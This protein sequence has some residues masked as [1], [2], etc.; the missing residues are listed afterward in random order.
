MALGSWN[1]KIAVNA[2]PE[3]LATAFGELQIVGAEY[4][5]IAYLGSQ[6][7]NGINHAV[8]AEQLLLT[9]KDTKNVVVMIFNEKEDKFTLSNIERVVES[10]SGMGAVT[11]DVKTDIPDDAKAVFDKAFTG[12]VGSK[13]E[14]FAL[15]ATQVVNG[16]DYIFAAEV[17]T[18]TKE[19]V[20]YVSLVTVN[21]VTDEIKFEDLIQGTDIK[22]LNY[23]FTWLK[24]KA[25][26]QGRNVGEWNVNVV[27]D[28]M[29]QKVATA[30]GKLND[31]VGAK[32]TPI[33]YLGEQVV[34]G[35]NHAVLAEQTL[36]LQEPVKNIVIVIFNEAPGAGPDDL[37]VVSIKTLVEGGTGFG[38]T[39]IDVETGDN[40][41]KTAQQL[42]DQRFGG[43]VGSVVTPFAL[44]A[45]QIVR[46]TNFVF[47]CEACPVLSDNDV[48]NKKA[49]LV[50]MNN[51]T[52]DVQFI[53]MLQPEINR[54][55]GAPLGEWP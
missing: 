16:V 18:V 21:S 46:G 28:G 39:Q 35:T 15:L 49:V 20:S 26:L 55:L 17:T 43:F 10:G 37:T 50:I 22:T 52:D 45:T 9:G 25:S 36:V 5:P 29:P 27:L 31:I 7:V 13:V 11:V 44:L 47:G 2:M 33:A 19:P 41:N 4:T 12:F 40:I 24:N 53:D 23:A 8:L 30:F 51:L 32:Y 6:V 1:I 42:F 38:A 3:K 34:N 14:P 54:S 48:N